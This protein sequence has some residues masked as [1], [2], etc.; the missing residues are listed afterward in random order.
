MKRK[1]VY[2]NPDAFTDTDLSVLKELSKSYHVTWF[3]IYESKKNVRLTLED[4]N[5][6]AQKYNIELRVKD[7]LVRR[8]DIRNFKFYY[9]ITKEINSIN[10]DL[11]YHCE[12]N[13]YWAICI[14]LFMKCKN[15]VLGIHDAS[16]HT[17]NFSFGLLLAIL[18]KDLTFKFHKNFITFSPNQQKYLREYYKLESYLVGM[19]CKDF[20]VSYQT[21]EPI[22]KGIKLLFFGSI[23]IYKG[24]DLLIVA[25]E[26]LRKKGVTNISLTIAGNGSCWQEYSTLI[27]TPELYNLQIRFIKNSEIPDLMAS[28]HFLVLPYRNATQSG[29]LFT[30][31]NYEL[32]IIAPNFGCFQETYNNNSAILYEPNELEKALYD[33]HNLTQTQFNEMKDSCKILKYNFS[34]E[35]IAQKYIYVFNTI[36]NK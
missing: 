36:I 18:F 7:P 31:I 4:A 12:R 30:A 15:V 34:E 5:S 25:L 3:Y 10:P 23:N 13:P 20:G 33:L 6:Y 17:F 28:H 26:N 9:Q 24:L 22:N 11:V 14:C 29:P 2:L 16:V 21:P 8:R 32:P 1:I 27:K 35:I 19:S